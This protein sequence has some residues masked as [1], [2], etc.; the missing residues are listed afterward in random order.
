MLNYVCLYRSGSK[1]L[2]AVN[3]NA[4]VNE[5]LHV[6]KSSTYPPTQTNGQLAEN[7]TGGQ[8]YLLFVYKYV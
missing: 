4:D 7:D 2:A 8:R 1:P 3:T 5:S 6:S